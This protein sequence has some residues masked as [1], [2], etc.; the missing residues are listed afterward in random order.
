MDK[1]EKVLLETKARLEKTIAIHKHWIFGNFSQPLFD[2]ME[3]MKKKVI[4]GTYKLNI[5]EYDEDYSKRL[6]SDTKMS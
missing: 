4:A 6:T 3:T 2:W 5:A 1:L